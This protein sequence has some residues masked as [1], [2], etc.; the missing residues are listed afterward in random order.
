[1]RKA[2]IAVLMLVS[3]AAHAATRREIVARVPAE[4][5]DLYALLA[6]QL[7]A[8]E[9][10]IAPLHPE[11]KP[12]PVYA[13]D[14]LPANGNRGTDLLKPGALEGSKLFLDRFQQLGMRGVVMTV[15]YPLLLDRFPNSA[16]YLAFYKQVVAEARKR[17]MTVEIESAVLFANLPFSTIQWD[18]SKVPFSQFTQ[19]RHDMVQKIVTEL[20]PDYL[21]LGAEPDTMGRL[22]GYTQ[23]FQPAAFAQHIAQVIAG[24]DRRS[25]KL[26]AGIGTWADLGY[27]QAE[28]LLPLDFIGLHIY[29]IDSASMTTAYQ[30]CN[31]ARAHGKTIVVDE[32]WL[33][34][35][36]PGESTDIAANTVIFARDSFSIFTALDEQ[37]L[38]FLDG[39]ARVEG[40]ALVSPFWST[41]FFGTLPYTQENAALSYGALVQKVNGVA[42]AN[43]QRGIFTPLGA[44]YGAL[45][46]GRR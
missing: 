25:T 34:K 15:G 2:L 44:Y 28:A 31:I 32:A 39:F 46:A 35:M 45:T 41:F 16:Q 14:L 18:W 38:H 9:A 37:F 26:G 20:A 11:L 7:N 1:M 17:G 4:Y 5:R 10:Q 3:S 27:V 19:E 8:A 21:E 42:S 43:I 30:A 13:S 29:P 6:S 40:V 36:L 23:M 33:Y 24:I 12:Q 22:T